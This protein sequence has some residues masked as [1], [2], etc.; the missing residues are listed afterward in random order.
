[1]KAVLAQLCLQYYLV[2]TFQTCLDLQPVRLML[3]QAAQGG[4]NVSPFFLPMTHLYI[5]S[6][7][8]GGSGGAVRQRKGAAGGGLLFSF[9]CFLLNL[10]PLCVLTA[11]AE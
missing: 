3:G 2:K 8:P 4:K 1:M 5:S 9:E 11:G 7:G 6:S 10:Q